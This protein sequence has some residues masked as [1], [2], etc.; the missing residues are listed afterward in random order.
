MK[1][2]IISILIMSL[3]LTACSSKPAGKEI[4]TKDPSEYKAEEKEAPEYAVEGEVAPDITIK[5][6]DDTEA[7][8]SDYFGKPTIMTFWATWC[9]YCVSEM[10][11][12]QMLQDKY[13]DDINI[14]A[15]NGGDDKETIEAFMEENGYTFEAA[16][17]SIEDSLIYDAQSIPVTVIFDKDGVIQFFVKGSLDGEKMFNEYFDPLFEELLQEDAETETA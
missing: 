13:G 17:V 16:Q 11:G 1:K 5:K 7:V 10:P 4:E 14:I 6:L 3:A 15:L 12:L 2:R 8:V 9:G